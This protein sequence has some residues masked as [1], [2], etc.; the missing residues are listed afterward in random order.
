[1]S[2]Q[3][4]GVRQV[5]V[6]CLVTTDHGVD[7]GPLHDGL[8][9]LVR[10]AAADGAPVPVSR[11]GVGDHTLLAADSLTL[12]VHASVE[13]VDGRRIM[14]LTIRPFRVGGDDAGTTFGAAPRAVPLAGDGADQPALARAVRAML[15][16]TL[17][18]QHSTTADRPVIRPSTNNA[19]K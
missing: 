11:V 12:L 7:T 5:S 14:A 10:D 6:L 15:A 4:Q 18:W 1:M 17:P 16:A 13:P 3:W 8:C 9:R 2:Q 19:N